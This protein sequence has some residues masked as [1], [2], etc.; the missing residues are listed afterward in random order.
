MPLSIDDGK[1]LKE[2]FEMLSIRLENIEAKLGISYDDDSEEDNSNEID[3]ND[4][5]NNNNI[6][7]D[8][9]DDNDESE[10]VTIREGLSKKN[11]RK[12]YDNEVNINKDSGENKES[13]VES[14]VEG[15][16]NVRF[17]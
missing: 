11:L 9:D 3:N 2:M 13:S 4:N 1:F 6:A 14:K 17:R 12:Q 8:N 16:K 5:N 15:I 7:N 10:E